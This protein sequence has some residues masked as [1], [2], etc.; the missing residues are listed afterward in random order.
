MRTLSCYLLALTFAAG[1]VQAV[2]VQDDKIL[3][4]TA[5]PV[6]F[7]ISSVLARNTSISV[8]NVP[9]R[10][11]PMSALGNFLETRA[12]QLS[13][14]FRNAGAVVTIW[15]ALEG[16]PAVHRC[17]GCKH[18]RRR[19]RRDEALVCESGRRFRGIAAASGRPV[20]GT[21]PAWPRSFRLLLAKPGQR[22]PL[23]RRSSPP[24]SFVCL[25]KIAHRLTST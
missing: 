9:E 12:E 13:E 14:Q 24:I 21:G 22:R 15:Q 10:A 7:S 8:Q 2:E 5:M 11:R 19:Y 17:A 20:D 16:R 4:L 25:R 18:S 6:T 23:Q 3:V 1:T